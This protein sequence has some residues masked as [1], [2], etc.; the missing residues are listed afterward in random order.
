MR[1]APIEGDPRTEALWRRKMGRVE[2]CD[3][4]GGFDCKCLDTIPIINK[5]ELPVNREGLDPW[6]PD[7]RDLETCLH[8]HYMDQ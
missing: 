2:R 3:N 1:V 6:E 7:R 4:C 8:Q 5:S